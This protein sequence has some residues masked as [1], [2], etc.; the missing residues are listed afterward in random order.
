[1]LG[2]P[3]FL[4]NLYMEKQYLQAKDAGMWLL[5]HSTTL[6]PGHVL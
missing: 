6:E 2:Y 1:M 3:R 4:W 5:G